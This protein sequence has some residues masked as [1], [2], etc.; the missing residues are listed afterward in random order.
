MDGSNTAHARSNTT[1]CIRTLPRASRPKPV[2]S[3][4][5][6]FAATASSPSTAFVRKASTWSGMA[7]A[8][9]PSTI[10]TTRALASIGSP[11]PITDFPFSGRTFSVSSVIS[12]TN[13]FVL[14]TSARSRA[15]AT[16]L[17]VIPDSSSS[18]VF[19]SRLP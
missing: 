3:A 9:S 10:G 6:T 16:T 5:R 14:L 17:T 12:V 18:R 8:C 7:P 15:T 11:T 19:L 2:S 4:A 13:A 1:L